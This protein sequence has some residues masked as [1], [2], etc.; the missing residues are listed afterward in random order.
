MSDKNFL[1][2]EE[3]LKIKLFGKIAKLPADGGHIIDFKRATAPI[4]DDSEGAIRLFCSGCGSYLTLTHPGLEALAARAGVR[5]LP[6]PLVGCYFQ[7]EQ[8]PAC[9]D[10]FAGAVFHA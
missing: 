5:R 1:A 6:E 7:A 8:C 2:L 9:G 3:E 10:G 4:S